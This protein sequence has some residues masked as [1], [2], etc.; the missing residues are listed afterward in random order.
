[1]ELNDGPWILP[2]SRQLLLKRGR[3]RR[4]IAPRMASDS[5]PCAREVTEHQLGVRGIARGPSRTLVRERVDAPPENGELLDYHSLSEGHHPDL[6]RSLV[7]KTGG[8]RP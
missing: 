4:T 6:D 8:A 1:M 7:G 3:P 5:S 2:E